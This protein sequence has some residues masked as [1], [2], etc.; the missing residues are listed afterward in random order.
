MSIIGKNIFT[1]SEAFK[2]I[3]KFSKI[4]IEFNRKAVTETHSEEW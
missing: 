2:C 1:A 3:N 4:R